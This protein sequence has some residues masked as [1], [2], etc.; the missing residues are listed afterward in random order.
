MTDDLDMKMRAALYE[1][2]YQEKQALL[3][4]LEEAGVPKQLGPEL[5]LVDRVRLAILCWAGVPKWGDLK[6]FVP[7]G[8]RAAIVHASAQCLA[9]RLWQP[10]GDRMTFCSLESGL[11]VNAAIA[12][13]YWDIATHVLELVVTWPDATWVPPADDARLEMI[14]LVYRRES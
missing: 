14:D 13:S 1:S 3:K 4:M 8:H 7:A 11:P 9:Q 5:P 6:A 2:V 12:Y 10:E